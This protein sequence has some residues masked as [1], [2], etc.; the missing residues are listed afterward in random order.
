MGIPM[1]PYADPFVQSMLHSE[2]ISESTTIRGGRDCGGGDC[3]LCLL[4]CG[5]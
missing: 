5:N 2:H 4:S 1:L 3:L